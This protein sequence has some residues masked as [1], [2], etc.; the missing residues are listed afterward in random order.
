M[1]ARLVYATDD[2]NG[3]CA[4]E[5]DFRGKVAAR[6]GYD[7]FDDQASWVFRVRVDARS[8]RP[9]AEIVTER[10]GAPS[11]KRTLDD[12]TC[13]A[14]SETVASAV[15]I[16]IDPLAKSPNRPDDA[17]PSSTPPP[18]AS[19]AAAPAPPPAA[20]PSPPPPLEPSVE[21][22]TPI[23]PFVAADA[24]ASVGRTAGAAIGGRAVVGIGYGALS[25]S[26]EGRGEATPGPVRL[27]P[28]DRASWSVFS[29]GIAACGHKGVLGL[30][31]TFAV[32]SLQARA[33]D[34][35]RP[36]LKGTFFA[37][38]GPRLELG[39]PI[40]DDVALRA[41]AEL[42]IPL[43]RTTFFIDGEPAWTAPVVQ[44]TF[45]LG[46]EVRFR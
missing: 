25:V 37:V 35:S 28:L 9:R 12:A 40:T 29:G 43:V 11:G 39:I 15:A 38:L 45:G 19:P 18:A 31:G 41:N 3:T 27:T 7:P 2:P 5:A 26:I 34:V 22:P 30:C 17:A 24:T 23:V 16:A 14:L 46:V 4:S 36:S 6:L 32:G 21:R 42:G 1:R 13:D 33:E 20:P 10:E 8:K 44:G